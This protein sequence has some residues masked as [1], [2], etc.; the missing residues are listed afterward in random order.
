M[1]KNLITKLFY[2]VLYKGVSN[3]GEF[4]TKVTFSII[5]HFS[6]FVQN[7]NSLSL[8]PEATAL[9]SGLQSTE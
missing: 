4:L 6:Q 3:K 8:E 5:N 9:P 7:F 1:L 2:L